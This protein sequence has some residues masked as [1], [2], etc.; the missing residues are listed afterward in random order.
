MQ[1]VYRDFGW[2]VFLSLEKF[3]KR[4]FQGGGYTAILDVDHAAPA[5]SS[6]DANRM[7]RLDSFFFSE[8]LKYL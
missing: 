4:S 3:C 6:S 2:Q 5:G 1:K 7:D 8:T